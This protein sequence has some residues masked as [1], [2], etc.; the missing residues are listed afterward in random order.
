MIYKDSKC[1]NDEVV[2]GI[3][4]DMA[5][6]E[7]AGIARPHIDNSGPLGKNILKKRSIHK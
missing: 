2:K 7:K 6:T 1:K 4:D 5:V 3:I